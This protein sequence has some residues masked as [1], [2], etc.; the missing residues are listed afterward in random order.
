MVKRIISLFLAILFCV[1]L[2]C[3][4]DKTSPVTD[5]D[6]TT[7]NTQSDNGNNDPLSSDIEL[8][9]YDFEDKI[10]YK[11]ETFEFIDVN[12]SADFFKLYLGAKT[13]GNEVT[14]PANTVSGIYPL[15]SASDTEKSTYKFD[16]T[17]GDQ[18]GLSSWIT[19]YLGLR[20]GGVMDATS[21]TGVWIA[22]RGKEIGMRTGNW[23]ETTYMSCD[24][25]FSSGGTVIVVD[26]PSEN[27]IKIYGGSEDHEIA[28][29]KISGATVEMY[30]PG[31]DSPSISDTTLSKI[32][33][34]GFAHLWNHHTNTEVKLK[35]ISAILSTKV[36]EN[37]ENDGIK[38]NTKD[39]FA[40]TWVAY[41]DAGRTV[42]ASETMPNGGKVGIFY[43]LWHDVSENPMPIYD[44]TAAYEKGGMDELWK[45][46]TL[47][48]RGFAHYWAQPYF[49]YYSS[50]DEWVIRKHGAML[51]EAGIDFVYFDTTNGLLYRNNYET[52]LK[53]WTKMRKE[54]LK[55]PDVCFILKSDN[56]SE[57]TLLWNYL[58]KI[59]LYEDMWFKWNGKPVIMFTD[60]DYTLTDEQKD[61]F[62]V[63]VSWATD[64]TNWYRRLKGKGCWPWASM[65]KQKPGY[66]PDVKEREIE[67]MVVMSGFWA[68][69]LAGRSYTSVTDEPMNRSEGAWDMGFGLYPAISGQGLAY[70]EQFDYAI[71]NSPEVLMI[72]GWN[73]WWAGRWEGGD[74]AGI[75]EAGEY[76]ISSNPKDKEYSYYVDNLNPEYSRDIEP[77]KGGFGDNYYYQT[78]I[79]VRNYKGSR[80]PETAFG[81]SAVD[82]NGSVAQWYS[83][84]PEFRDVYGDTT[85]R[86]HLSHV[87]RLNYTNDTGRNDILTAKVSS[88][89]D[90]LYFYVEC[91]EDIT[92][93][94]GDNWMN[95][96]IKSDEDS[97]N[98]WYGFDYLINRSGE[99][100]KASVEKFKDG[101]NFEK[102]SDAEYV[103]SGK[104]LVI[105]V[106]KSDIGY[107]GES[108]DFKWADNSVTDGDIMGF[109]DN[110]DAAPDARF[111]YRYTTAE[112]K[113][114]VPECLTADM[115]VFKANGYNAY[116]NGKQVRIGDST[117][118]TLL[119]T[120][121]DF[122]LPKAFLTDVLGI[123]CDGETEYN[124]YGTTYV[125]ANAPVEKSGKTVTVTADG[126]LVIANEKIT[127][128][129]VLD[130]LYRSLY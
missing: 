2:L 24:Y 121:Y 119:A 22:M 79:N 5:T 40:D 54:G 97:T 74:A 120:G 10:S 39:V 35:N 26:D 104:T 123:T 27:I 84:G 113:T 115:A 53:V 56:T 95:L 12:T 14:L 70:Q 49:G 31:S 44:H 103:V 58:Y 6:D 83:V 51:S 90:N 105:K 36:V 66:K 11:N 46:M 114:S 8:A 110:G 85:Q 69:S 124:H 47:G 7:E 108:L 65:Y 1:S 42:S 91:A 43:F 75:E 76:I 21:H 38:Q 30:A 55:T 60:L 37:Q 61:F 78:V 100:G 88:D 109:W 28:T 20:L 98:G 9:D 13:E 23:P 112:A 92:V 128:E 106:K 87:G 63:R 48:P 77:M 19:F 101:W 4:C 33:S 73:E 17:C 67:Q 29:V 41:D 111:C 57:L 3:S 117:K 59:G 99:G 80:Q 72:T 64:T 102:V 32:I 122:Y 118:D 127:D 25:D 86:D 62:T 15:N 71:S 94:E 126:L 130:T 125:K 129:K 96:F 68:T 18:A 52:V 93:R 81:Q 82:L 50:D 45:T 34:G 116:I 107:N 89:D 16:L